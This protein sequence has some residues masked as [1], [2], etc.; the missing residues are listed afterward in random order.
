MR[1]RPLLRP[2]NRPPLSINVNNTLN[3]VAFSFALFLHDANILAEL[4]TTQTLF[5]E[6]TTL[7]E[8]H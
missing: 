1:Y 8:T 2:P 4:H 3:S 6:R 5:L 7:D